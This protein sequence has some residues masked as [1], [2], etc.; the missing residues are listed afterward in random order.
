M[1]SLSLCRSLFSYGILYVSSPAFLC[2]SHADA[3]AQVYI[4]KPGP[5][6]YYSHFSGLY[7][8]ACLF[9]QCIQFTLLTL[10]GKL[11]RNRVL[12]GCSYAYWATLALSGFVCTVCYG[13]I[14]K[15]DCSA[16]E[17]LASLLALAALV[18]LYCFVQPSAFRTSC[19]L[20]GSVN[21]PVRFG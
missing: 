12:A 10:G 9:F 17:A 7:L 3:C 16:I 14:P 18:F 4:S 2:P 15:A 19:F 20:S 1:R 8:S 13:L 5:R 21:P 11:S 6:T